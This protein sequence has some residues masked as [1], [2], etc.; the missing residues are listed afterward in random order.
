MRCPL[1]VRLSSLVMR[2]T[3]SRP[4]SLSP[5]DER[6]PTLKVSENSMSNS[7][8]P[9]TGSLHSSQLYPPPSESDQPMSYRPVSGLKLYPTFTYDSPTI[10]LRGLPHDGHLGGSIQFAP[11]RRL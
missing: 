2:Y 11:P 6:R 9:P 1:A 8:S 5:S 3:P 10:L 7:V 4:R